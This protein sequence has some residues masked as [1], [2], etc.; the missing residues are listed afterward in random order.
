[1]KKEEKFNDILDACLE[2]LSRGDTPEQCLANYPEQAAQLEPLLR[3]AAMVRVTTS[4]MP[5]PESRAQGW[6][7]LSKALR[8]ARPQRTSFFYAMPRWA[9]A[10]VAFIIIL[11]AGGGTAGAAA[12]SLP[13]SFLYPVKLATER[14]QISLAFSDL[15]KTELYVRLADRRVNE[16]TSMVEK[17]NTE[18]LAG[19]A[20]RLDELLVSI[21]GPPLTTQP[22]IMKSFGLETASEAPARG[23]VPEQATAPESYA[24]DIIPEPATAPPPLLDEGQSDAS[25]E[26][27]TLGRPPGFSAIKVNTA[28]SATT[29]PS[30]QTQL[31]ELLRRYQTEHPEKL[32]AVLEKLPP[33]LK[34]LLEGIINHSRE[35]YQQAL[36]TWQPALP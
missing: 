28:E 13:D 9:V 21:A 6:Q 14:V 24:S 34:A 3:T 36:E 17:G 29:L 19:V 1:M 4:I 12:G 33:E 35:S 15:S 10:I 16:I 27:E 31:V 23:M 11:A 22:A 18:N 25:G 5:R 30:E 7:Q 26:P 2:G 32:Q 20:Q 8:E